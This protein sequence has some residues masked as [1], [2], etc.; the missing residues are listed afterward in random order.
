M[1]R[2]DPWAKD[3]RLGMAPAT[4][5]HVTT[6]VVSLVVRGISGVPDPTSSMAWWSHWRRTEERGGSAH[7]GVSWRHRH[8]DQRRGA[9]G[10]E[11]WCA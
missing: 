7:T 8:T 5:P 3:G 6:G 1:A 10:N 4:S 11:D 9:V 2:K